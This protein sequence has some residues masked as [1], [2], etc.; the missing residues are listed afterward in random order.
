MAIT[1]APARFPAGR[2]ILA[3]EEFVGRKAEP[4]DELTVSSSD[5]VFGFLEGSVE[6][7]TSSSEVDVFDVEEEEDEGENSGNGEENKNYWDN[8]HNILQGT[9]CRTTVLE[10]GIRGVT[11]DALKE[12][13]AQGCYCKCGK[14]SNSCRI[15]LMKEVSNRLRN[16]GY[17]SAICRSKW[18]SSPD[19]PSGEHTYIDVIDNTSSKKGEIRVIVEL[20]FRAEFEMARASEDYNQLISRLPDVFVGKVERLRALIK[21][22]CSAAKKCM[23]DKKM[24]MGPWRKQKYVQAKWFSPCERM[25]GN[26]MGDRTYSKQ[27][28]KPVRASMLTMALM[29]MPR[30]AV[31]VV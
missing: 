12:I 22:L 7:S 31:A 16:A 14:A 27:M 18:R 20:N 15:C 23:K 6:S 4:S 11:K 3:Y 30:K 25:E 13:E 29:E 5:S 10:S 2:R 9:L 28:I 21:I 26:S 17:N 24:H 19:V 8:Q 1:G